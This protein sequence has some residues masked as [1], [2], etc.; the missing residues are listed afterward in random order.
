[1][2]APV[3]TEYVAALNAGLS[4]ARVHFYRFGFDDAEV[5]FATTTTA[6][7]INGETW[8]PNGG[9]IRV[10]GMGQAYGNAVAGSLTLTV[11]GVDAA[12]NRRAYE[13]ADK[14]PGRP[15]ETYVAHF[16][17]GRMLDQMVTTFSGYMAR[18][19]GAKTR[20]S[21]RITLH[22]ESWLNGRQ[23]SPNGYYSDLDQQERFPGDLSCQFVPRLQ[24]YTRTWPP[25]G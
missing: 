25:A 17:G 18:I 3:F 6:I 22:C 15:I 1:M 10:E 9:V 12:M 20:D 13:E 8:E 14:V 21:R 16:G 2:P 7:E 23:F 24:F 11:N 4:P 19:T 5:R